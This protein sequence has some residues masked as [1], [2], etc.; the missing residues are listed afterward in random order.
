MQMQNQQF[1]MGQMLS[2]MGPVDSGTSS[3]ERYLMYRQ[4]AGMNHYGIGG[5]SMPM[6][7]S[8][9]PQYSDFITMPQYSS[10]QSAQFAPTSFNQ[11]IP[12]N[13]S[14]GGRAPAVMGAAPMFNQYPTQLSF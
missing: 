9:A 11:G 2:K 3:L 5:Y 14:F 8:L 1:M 6:S 4:P 10:F 12:S 13:L 7:T